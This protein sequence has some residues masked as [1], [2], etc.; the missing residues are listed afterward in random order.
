MT[1]EDA[2]R[3][4][5]AIGIGILAA[6]HA[7]VTIGDH[8]SQITMLEYINDALAD[9]HDILS[10]SFTDHFLDVHT[11]EAGND[12]QLMPDGVLRVVRLFSTSDGSEVKRVSI[13]DLTSARYNPATGVLQYRISGD[14]IRFSEAPSSMVEMWYVKAFERLSDINDSIDFSV[15]VDWH[16]YAVYDVTARLLA[17]EESSFVFWEGRKEEM[18]RRFKD[19][20]AQRDLSQ[21][22]V[23]DREPTDWLEE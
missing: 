3:A 18:R 15:P 22:P 11:F 12:D 20:A 7:E 16:R 10:E 23:E 6:E 21:Q 13:A 2:R 19:I 1:T 9:L 8:I 17:Q 5:K 4:W 14:H